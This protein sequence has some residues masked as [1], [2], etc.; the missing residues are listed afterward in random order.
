VRL[1]AETLS[2]I[3]DPLFPAL[4][5][6]RT[7]EPA[8]AGRSILA[9]LLRPLESP[10]A[11]QAVPGWLLPHQGDAVARARTI[12][13]RFGGV[14]VADG[15]GLGKT[16]IGLALA[17]LEQ[18]TGAD[19][20][21]VVPAPLLDEWARAAD[22]VGVS[23]RMITH[24]A[25]ARTRAPMLSRDCRLVLVD[26]AHAFRNA[27]TRRYAGLARLCAG[28]RVALLTATPIN[29]TAADAAAL[30]RL[31]AGRDRFRELGV[32]DLD[33]ALGDPG[34][35]PAALALGA[36]SV[37]RSRRL[38][39]SL[40]PAL[41]GAFPRRLLRPPL[42]YDLR[43]AYGGRLDEVL[44]ALAEY[45]ALLARTERAAGLLHLGLL[46]RL[47]SSRAALRRTLLRG[48]SFLD[49]ALRAAD[50]GRPLGRREFQRACPRHDDN[51]T[52]LVLW[53]LLGTSGGAL[54]PEELRACRDGVQR[55]LD[56][57]P[58]DAEDVKAAALDALLAA[59]RGGVRT[60][61][62]TE[63][64]DTALDLLRRLRT[65][66]R[67]MAALGDGAWAGGTPLRRREA[68]AAFGP[69]TAAG[70][71]VLAAD[72]LI[73][74]DVASEG[75][76][77][78]GANRLVNYDLPWNPVRVMQRIGRIDRLQ[79]AHSEIEVVHLLPAHGAEDLAGVL[80]RLRRKL[81]T[82]GSLL[83]AEPDPLAALWWVD[84]ETAVVDPERESWTRVEPF[85]ARE[86]WRAVLGPVSGVAR[87]PVVAAA[88]L[89][90][91]GAPAVGV[92]LALE[93]RDGRSVP[94]PYVVRRGAAPVRSAAQLGTLATRAIGGTPIATRPRDFADALAAVLSDARTWLLDLAAARHGAPQPAPG[95]AAAL[96]VVQRAAHRAHRLRLDPTRADEAFQLLAH[97]LPVGLD[98]LVAEVLRA[99]RRDEDRVTAVAELLRSRL[100]PGG[101]ELRPP[102][103]LT[104]VAAIAVVTACPS[105]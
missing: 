101:P 89:D 14:L 98:R 71:G 27:R 68:L 12:L 8:V 63:F 34:A 6:A 29:N 97:D 59:R 51:D 95:R 96:A 21:A 53:E 56:L 85:E 67:V 24:H 39:E 99:E 90:D 93:W 4:A 25:L 9:G 52:Q 38:V 65:R 73:A 32:V 15:V 69:G 77:L 79:S 37:C 54:P 88:A 55:V 33:R 13:D 105:R 66:H 48:R 70:H 28:R 2:G 102:A 62:F 44:D 72:V 30:I 49:E 76:N 92:L 18:A 17:Y 94:L 3:A 22:A 36:V 57:L 11:P 47:E 104:L 42:R 35:E 84:G 87:G 103:R 78:Q 26:E 20:V 45:A 75:L 41:R 81:A 91:D 16:Y 19:A 61:V 10:G 31:F 60:V 43:A 23:L 100:P 86:R 50:A 74:T 58:P 1:C 7:V 80:R 64:R 82:A 83:A 40:F 46:R 5:A